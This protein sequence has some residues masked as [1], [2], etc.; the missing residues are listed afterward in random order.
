MSLGRVKPKASQSLS[1]GASN[2]PHSAN[3]T[4]PTRTHYSSRNEG[5]RDSRQNSQLGLVAVKSTLHP[6]NHTIPTTT[7]IHTTCTPFFL[8][9]F[10][11]GMPLNIY[12]YI[13]ICLATLVI[14]SAPHPSCNS[15]ATQ[16]IQNSFHHTIQHSQRFSSILRLLL[17]SLPPSR[18]IAA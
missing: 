17:S 3:P 2:D 16:T 7:F 5:G 8:G 9:L 11:L 12:I 10:A 13:Y 6:L 4:R 1:G 18:L 14:A 15:Q